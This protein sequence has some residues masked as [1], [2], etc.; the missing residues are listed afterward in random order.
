MEAE[1]KEDKYH[2]YRYR[3]P[4]APRNEQNIPGIWFSKRFNITVLL[5]LG[6]LMHG[7]TFQV[8]GISLADMTTNRV[9]VNQTNNLTTMKPSEF[10]WDLK[11]EEIILSMFWIGFLLS[12]CG[13][14]VAQRYGGARTLGISMMLTGIILA[15]NPI[16]ARIHVYLFAL[17]Q[18]TTGVLQGFFLASTAEVFACWMP[19]KERTVLMS[20]AI[21][22]IYVA[23][24]VMHPFF[25]SLAYKWQWTMNFYVSGIVCFIWSIIWLIYV[26]NEPMKDKRISDK[27][28][29]YIWQETGTLLRK[30]DIRPYED[31][32][33]SSSCWAL[34]FC[35][36]AFGWAS[37]YT[38][39]YLPL[40]YIKDVT[41]KQTNVEINQVY[42]ILLILDII[43]I[44]TIP[45]TGVL[46]N[47]WL[48]RG[49]RIPFITELHK[50][51]IA[52]V[53]IVTGFSF[54][55]FALLIAHFSPSLICLLAIKPFLP[56][57]QIILEMIP[58]HMAPNHSSLLSGFAVFWQ[59]VGILCVQTIIKGTVEDHR[60]ED[61]NICF[62]LSAAVLV[63]SALIFLCF[64]S[65]EPQ[66][67]STISQSHD[68]VEGQ[69]GQYKELVKLSSK[70]N[71]STSITTCC[72][73]YEDQVSDLSISLT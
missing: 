65:S 51:I 21:N 64:G 7:I 45:I 1:N 22:G 39:S 14:F 10:Q 23:A 3:D 34:F 70:T 11:T 50:I 58:V 4:S 18:L 19:M 46:I 37:A 2:Q 32:L 57:C 12:I 16:C 26:K 44:F 48:S 9:I 20:F 30:R 60:L 40:N 43:N 71:V 35:K 27:E 41:N 6:Y 61:W 15:M 68:V 69:R 28:F 29:E 47:F 49:D 73:M 59:T 66:P 42:L 38:L 62:Q 17:C 8:T 33:V 54:V 53:Y 24:V 72:N 13:G 5:F 56:Y 55:V 52:V 31:I 63:S 36:F 25:S 67:W